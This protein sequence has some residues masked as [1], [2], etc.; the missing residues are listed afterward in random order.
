MGGD[1]GFAWN[2][3]GD[4]ARELT[5]FVKYVGFTPL[6]VITCA[7]KTG[8]EIMGRGDEFG[9]LEAGKLADVLVVDGDVLQDIAVLE[10]RAQV[11]RGDA[12]RRGQG[13]PARQALPHHR[14][15]RKMNAA[16]S[17]TA[18]PWQGLEFMAEA[19]HSAGARRLNRA[20]SASASGTTVLF[21]HGVLRNWRT[22]FQLIDGL[23]D[24]FCLAGLDFRGHGRSDRT[25]GAYRV[26]DYVE[27]ALAIL[28]QLDA[29]RLVL[30]GHS[31]GAM[32]ALAAAAEA[33]D[34]VHAI[35]LEDPPLST[36]GERLTATPLGRFFAG[37]RACVSEPSSPDALFECFSNIIVA[38]RPDGTP[39]RVRDQRDE[40]ARRFSAE[41]LASIDPTLIDPDHRRPLARRLRSRGDRRARPL[42]GLAP[43]S[44]R[45]PTAAC[46]PTA[47]PHSSPRTCTVPP[48]SEST[49]PAPAI[50]STGRSPA[51]LVEIIRTA[52]DGPVPN[53]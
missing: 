50:P 52:G 1:Y 8:A 46:S 43:A 39:L 13:R 10:D 36:M 33:P 26:T 31:L 45:T 17:G 6:E 41:S 30:H 29:R 42:P 49:S 21:L 32:V 9:T 24:R 44:R 48:S 15:V 28:P 2:P 11:P 53:H 7:T 16:S 20:Q 38:E 14:H 23:R 22:F 12:G 5:F 35:V 19:H 37:V 34:R 3:H 27:D 25:P 47:M 18:F 40:L 51:R 4:Y